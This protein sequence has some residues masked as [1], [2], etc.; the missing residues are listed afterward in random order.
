D[1]RLL[2]LSIIDHHRPSFTNRPVLFGPL[3]DFLMPYVGDQ[4]EA[5]IYKKLRHFWI[6]LDRT[7][8][9]AFI[10]VY[11]GPTVNI[12]FRTILR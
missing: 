3:D 5:Q 6:M 9:D 7:L 10:H 12:I 1:H 11:I 4:S 2:L 8:P